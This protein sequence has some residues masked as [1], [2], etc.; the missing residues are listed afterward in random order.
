S[1]S[2]TTP[3][4]GQVLTYTAG[5]W[6]PEANLAGLQSASVVLVLSGSQSTA[7][8]LVP[9]ASLIWGVFAE[10]VIAVQG[11]ATYDIGTATD[12]DLW[13][14]AVSGPTTDIDDF[15]LLNPFYV[16]SATDVVVTATS[17]TFTAGSLRLTAYYWQKP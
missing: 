15:T 8:G 3:A 10:E 9:A 6:E 12:T 7:V 13:A 17:G 2:T 16:V 4:E 14:G 11:P 1:L 5:Q